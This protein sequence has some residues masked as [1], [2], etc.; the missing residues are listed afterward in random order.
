MTNIVQF[1]Y[2]DLQAVIKN[3]FLE[4]INEIKSLPAQPVKSDRCTLPEA[5]ELTGLKKSAL[6]KMTMGGSIPYEKFGKRLVFSRKELEAWIKDRTVRKHSPEEMATQ[7]LAKVATKKM[8]KNQ[9]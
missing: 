4:T 1:N 5:V 9:G 7:Q 2:D 6:Y 8:I 3:C